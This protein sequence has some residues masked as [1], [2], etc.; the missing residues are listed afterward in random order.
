MLLSQKVQQLQAFVALQTAEKGKAVASSDAF[1]AVD[2]AEPVTDW[3][4]YSN[5]YDDYD[6]DEEVRCY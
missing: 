1:Y 6:D 2:V 3:H 5:Y 4:D